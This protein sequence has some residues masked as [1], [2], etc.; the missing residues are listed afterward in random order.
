MNE[1]SPAW[2]RAL[3][4]EPLRSATFWFFL[5]LL[6][7]ILE[8]AVSLM[9]KIAATPMRDMLDI[10]IVTLALVLG[11]VGYGFWLV[12]QAYREARAAVGTEHEEILARYSYLTARMYI[13]AGGC[14]LLCLRVA[15]SLVR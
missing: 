6:G 7:L 8:A 15:A 5:L 9:V 4:G 10:P 12:V 11:L 2:R 1:V 3:S 13:I 14:T